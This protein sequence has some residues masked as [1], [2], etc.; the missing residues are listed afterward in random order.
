MNDMNENGEDVERKQEMGREGEG[1]RDYAEK[2]AGQLYGG[3]I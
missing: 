2:L 1:E 3:L